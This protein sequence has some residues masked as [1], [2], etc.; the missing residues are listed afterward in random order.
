LFAGRK[1]KRKT[2]NEVEKTSGKRMR[3]KNLAPEDTVNR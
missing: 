3:Q 1:K 2:R